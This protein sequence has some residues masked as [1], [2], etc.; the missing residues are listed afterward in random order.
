MCFNDTSPTA[1]GRVRCVI[2]LAMSVA[3]SLVF[4]YAFA[5][6][7]SHGALT[8]IPKVSAYV[9]D[10]WNQ[11]CTTVDDDEEIMTLGALDKCRGN[12]GVYR[13]CAVTTMF[14]LLS[15]IGAKL[16]PAMNREAWPAKYAMYLL[17]VAASVF[18]P[19]HPYF[20]GL[21]VPVARAL[22]AIFI[23]VQQII[24]IDVAYNWNDSWVTKSNHADMLEPGTGI[25]W[26][27][28]IV[29]SC[30]IMFVAT[31]TSM[32]LLFKY[33]GSDDCGDNQTV[34]W[35]TLMWIVVTT[36]VQLAF[37]N[38]G[39]LTSAVLS[40][41]ATYLVYSAMAKNPNE[42]CNPTLH[43][44]HDPVDIVVGVVL[45]FVS[46]AWTG[47]SFTSDGHLM[48]SGDHGETIGIH[49][50]RSPLLADDNTSISGV[51]SSH[52]DDSDAHNHGA[53]LPADASPLADTDG[54]L[55]KLNIVLAFVSAWVAMT[56]TGWG[57]LSG[58]VESNV[59]NPDKSSVNMWIICVSQWIAMAL[60]LWTLAAPRLFPDR[61]FS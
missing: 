23:V 21:Y 37:S 45:T 7:L 53:A 22:A 61:E 56:L 29:A 14:F 30:G 8:R 3:L 48:C 33:F 17:L 36:V 35:I 52:D 47:W 25:H 44:D 49:D 1:T 15:A 28:A 38:T 42:Q 12:F 9:I 40:L 16:R 51:V 24:L 32:V 26:L 18:V 5:P 57:S 58:E 50:S 59:A 34:L 60:Y 2:L 46:L 19:N 54:L 39:L 10:I 13:V 41:Y 4:Q 31:I 20:G 27:R 11:G 6:A 55:W 43:Q